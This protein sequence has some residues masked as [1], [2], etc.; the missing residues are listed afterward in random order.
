MLRESV[1]LEQFITFVRA[2]F[3]VMPEWFAGVF[4]HLVAAILV[5]YMLTIFFKAVCDA[6]FS[7]PVKNVAAFIS[8][9]GKS[10]LLGT[11]KA[12]ESPIERP[13]SKLAVRALAVLLSYM[14]C[15]IFWGLFL[16]VVLIA[17]VGGFPR[18]DWLRQLGG[19]GVLLFLF[20]LTIFFRAEADRDWLALKEQWAI[21][22]SAAPQKCNN[23]SR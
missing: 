19:W 16:L 15:V 5:V 12:L 3:T 11:F 22:R 21:V 9:I 1:L 10:I 18:E 23:K 7:H 17:I 20:Y 13:R 4:S 8:S 14:M 6:S 2:N